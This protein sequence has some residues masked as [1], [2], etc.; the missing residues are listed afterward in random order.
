M[1]FGQFIADA[2]KKAKIS[3][4][5]FAG[6]IK[7]EDGTSISPQYLNDIERDRRNPP[8]E[9]ILKQIA[10]Q[11]DL[12]LDYLHYLA[13]KLPDDVLQENSGPEQVNEAFR[14][15]RSTLQNKQ[16]NNEMDS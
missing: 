9:Y 7:K 13:G 10:E 1:S 11:L 2:R 4:K 6:M 3:Q 5:S 15:F 8:N 14:A 16:I 12:S